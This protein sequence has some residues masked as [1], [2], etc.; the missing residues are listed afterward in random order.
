[1]TVDVL[2]DICPLEFVYQHSDGY[3]LSKCSI[4]PHARN[5]TL[6]HAVLIYRFKFT[7]CAFLL[8]PLPFLWES[9]FLPPITYPF[10]AP[11][12]SPARLSLFLSPPPPPPPLR[13]SPHLSQWVLPFSRHVAEFS[14]QISIFKRGS[15]W[16]KKSE[17]DSK[18]KS[19]GNL[20]RFGSSGG[21]R[22]QFS[23]CPEDEDV[24]QNVWK[25]C[26]EKELIEFGENL[27]EAI[28][29]V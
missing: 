23:N 11:P 24:L 3:P 4:L 25:V 22:A 9:V 15:H 20:S 19:R 8:H 28:V 1:M 10:F 29:M 18:R 21:S 14:L 16:E 2:S 7:L 17:S 5:V 6:F 26:S 13:F 12:S 27:V